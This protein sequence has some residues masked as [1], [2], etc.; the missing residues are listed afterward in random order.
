L[1][2]ASSDEHR[3]PTRSGQSEEGAGADQ[4]EAGLLH[5]QHQDL[6][7]PGAEEGARAAQGGERQVRAHERSAQAPQLRESGRK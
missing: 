7:E 4:S 6:L 5:A 2:R 1:Q 3:P